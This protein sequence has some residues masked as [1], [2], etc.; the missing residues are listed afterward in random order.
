M[1][2]ENVL[3]CLKLLVG[4]VL[5]IAFADVLSLR[6]SYAAGIITLLTIQDTRKETLQIALKRVIIFIV[7]TG[8]SV[9]VFSSTGYTLLAFTIVMVPYLF[10][11]FEL[12]MKEAI[13]PI[14]V[15]CTHYISEQSCEPD[16]I[17]NEFL[18]LAVGAGTGIFLNMFVPDNK[19]TMRRKLKET[20]DKMREIF[21]SMAAGIENHANMSQSDEFF[22]EVDAMLQELRKEAV[23]YSNNHFL[24][25]DDYYF[26]YVGMRMEQ[27]RL[28]K[29]IYQDIAGLSMV[30]EQA[31][32]VAEY[33][34]E[35]SRDFHEMNNAEMLLDH[36]EKL[37]DYFRK[38]S[39]PLSRAEFENRALLFHIIESMRTLVTLKKTFY[40]KHNDDQDI[41][42]AATENIGSGG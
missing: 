10:A 7:M 9:V 37:Y 26:E 30:P 27:C 32:R 35:I 13:A 8:I 15:L 4:S 42:A 41:V 38:A 40:L 1:N 23:T 19:M 3:K 25:S 39:L 31:K 6:F 36:L 29:Q 34:Y 17:L 22:N 11:C 18:I 16:M 2:K 28:L 14:A 21:S 20:E 24:S 5:A 33:F 12:K